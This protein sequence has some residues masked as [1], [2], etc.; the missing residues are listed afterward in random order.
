[1]KTIISLKISY[2]KKRTL[3]CYLQRTLCKPND[4][5]GNKSLFGELTQLCEKENY[6]RLKKNRHL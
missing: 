3:D 4:S 2:F 6:L 1:M 5:T